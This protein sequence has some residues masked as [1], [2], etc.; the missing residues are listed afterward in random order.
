MD[1]FSWISPA[2]NGPILPTP[3]AEIKRC[4][5]CSSIFV[6]KDHC[7]ACGFQLRYHKLGLPW[8]DNGMFKLQEVWA[9]QLHQA[10][11][12]PWG[13][14]KRAYRKADYQFF[15]RAVKRWQQVVTQGALEEDKRLVHL[16]LETILTSLPWQ[17]QIALCRELEGMAQLG[18]KPQYWQLPEIPRPWWQKR[19]YGC[20]LTVLIALWGTII[21][22]CACACWVWPPQLWISF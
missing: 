7:E 3:P 21:A 14:R 19:I 8:E 6:E 22:V 17:G 16:E 1:N 2:E 9:K 11:R 18:F 10:M 20:R 4:P 5:R 15:W 12:L 13:Q